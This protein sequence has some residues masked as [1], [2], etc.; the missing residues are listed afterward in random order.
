MDN[1]KQHPWESEGWSGMQELLDEEMPISRSVGSKY[2]YLFVFSFLLFSLASWMLMGDGQGFTGTP[3]TMSESAEILNKDLVYQVER[4]SV[5]PQNTSVNKPYLSGARPAKSFTGSSLFDNSG[6]EIFS[7]LGFQSAQFTSAQ[8]QLFQGHRGEW[9]PYQ[10]LPV[11][12]VRVKSLNSPLSSAYLPDLV[13]HSQAKPRKLSP[14][15]EHH[16][17]LQNGMFWGTGLFTGVSLVGKSKWHGSVSLGYQYLNDRQI[18]ADDQFTVPLVLPGSSETIQEPA[19]NSNTSLDLPI[20]Q[21]HKH[22]LGIQG[23]LQRRLTSRFSLGAMARVSLA[24]SSLSPDLTESPLRYYYSDLGF[25]KQEFKSRHLSVG[26]GLVSS[27]AI[28]DDWTFFT[29][30]IF[31][32][33]FAGLNS[34]RNYLDH[35]IWTVESG[36]RYTF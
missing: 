5:L 16:V 23:Q 25:S 36:F 13:D 17:Q 1:R 9:T 31:S 20:I 33:Q 15:I 26:M 35:Y 22:R 8:E 18:E 6:V 2:L 7:T 21:V 34:N 12:Q 32:K 11:A 28:N 3:L 27:Y 4:S 30:G 24:W 19:N 29:R 10:I 14:F